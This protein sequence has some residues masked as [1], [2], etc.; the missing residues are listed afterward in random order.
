MTNPS[1][2]PAVPPTGPTAGSFIGPKL[3]KKFSELFTYYVER[4]GVSD[5]QLS[6]WA[7]CSHKVIGD[8]KSGRCKPRGE[9]SLRLLGGLEV[10]VGAPPGSLRTPE[11][12]GL[13]AHGPQWQV[14]NRIENGSAYGRHLSQCRKEAKQKKIRRRLPR[15]EWS[16]QTEAIVADHLKHQAGEYLGGGTIGPAPRKWRQKSPA[17]YTGASV[18]RHIESHERFQGFMA[19]RQ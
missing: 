15:A 4:S 12:L 2:P 18:R 3:P 13:R 7:G 16:A 9:K 11:L 1:L 19:Q 5:R 6:R 14:K 17:G 8:W 10:I